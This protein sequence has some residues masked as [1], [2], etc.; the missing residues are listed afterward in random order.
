[1]TRLLRPNERGSV[2]EEVLKKINM[3]AVC[4][5]TG[6]KV[7]GYT[8][9]TV[10]NCETCVLTEISCYAALCYDGVVR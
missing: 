8:H 2:R 3:A 7:N 9:N 10:T 6:G 1:M 5:S 4:S